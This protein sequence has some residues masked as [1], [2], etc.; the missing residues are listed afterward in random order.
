[1]EEKMSV[2]PMKKKY[3]MRMQPDEEIAFIPERKFP[4]Y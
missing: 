2:V 3:N 1:M 4:A